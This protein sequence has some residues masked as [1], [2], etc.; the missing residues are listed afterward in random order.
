M[1]WQ[2][3]RTV[4]RVNDVIKSSTVR[5]KTEGSLAY[6]R[7]QLSSRIKRKAIHLK[8]VH[9]NKRIMENKIKKIFKKYQH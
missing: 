1:I 4:Y 8:E 6:F 9:K 3:K 7:K 2:E 5:D